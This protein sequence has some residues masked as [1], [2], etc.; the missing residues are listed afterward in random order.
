MKNKKVIFLLD[1]DAFFASCHMA[2]DP[3]LKN[4][5]LVVSSP[6]RRAIITTASYNARSFG[7][8]AGMP[9]FKAKELCPDIFPVNSDFSLYINFSQKVFDVIYNN[10]TKKIEVASIDECYLDVTHVWKKYKTVKKLAEAIK[11]KIHQELNLTCSIGISTNKFLAKTCVDFN[12]PNGVSILL[13]EDI[14]STLWPLPVERMFM[15]GPLTTK[16]LN[17]NNI[18]TIE[19]L[20]LSDVNNII[21][22]LGK[23]GL[24]LWSWANGIGDD[25]VE[26]E[27]NELK[28]IGNEFTLN[29]TTA[30]P[31]EIEEMIYELSLKVSQ[32][33]RKRFLKGKTI[34][35]II[36]YANNNRG[37]DLKQ[38]KKHNTK[39]ETINEVT[40]NVEKIYSVAKECFY[41]LW[42]GEQILLVGVRL[43][44]LIDSIQDKKQL[45]FEDIDLNDTLNLNDIGKIIYDLELKFGKKL[46]F[47]ADQLIKFNDKNRSQSKYLKNDNVHIS[48]EEI[49]KKWQKHK[50]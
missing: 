25:N 11:N 38:R 16:T 1:M 29:Y 33:A 23:R 3:S 40:N 34:A 41:E 44:N 4:K 15:I 28:S 17:E 48:N 19:Q 46:I 30:N 18:F 10:F 35:I 6:N 9:M 37:F 5:N 21:Q 7:I 42:N 24:T 13:P 2:V 49:I 8:R 12:K 14:S 26:H 47:T 36:K 20:A 43:T 31:E 39:Q 22:L 45:S 50:R 32:R 27:S